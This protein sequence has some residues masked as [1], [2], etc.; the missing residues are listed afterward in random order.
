M[1]WSHIATYLDLLVLLL[2]A[3]VGA[4]LFKKLVVSNRIG[5]KFCRTVL[6]VNTHQL[7]ESE[8]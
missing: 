3:V 2:S 1:D 7:T 8:F 5:M 6:Q 4:T